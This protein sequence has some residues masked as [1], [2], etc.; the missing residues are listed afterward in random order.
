MRA[1]KPKRLK[2][3]LYTLISCAVGIWIMWILLPEATATAAVAARATL[4]LIVGSYL[5]GLGGWGL[6]EIYD[7]VFPETSDTENHEQ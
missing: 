4:I 3:L 1:V 7:W 6:Y 2:R 5:G